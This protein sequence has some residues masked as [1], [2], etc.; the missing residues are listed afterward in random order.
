[1]YC[2]CVQGCHYSK[3]LMF[4]VANP[5]GHQKVERRV[6]LSARRFLSVRVFILRVVA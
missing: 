4:Y 5:F 2:C 3:S 1:V 6:K